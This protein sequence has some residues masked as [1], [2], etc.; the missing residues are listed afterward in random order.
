MKPVCRRD[1]NIGIRHIGRATKIPNPNAKVTGIVP[2]NDESWFDDW[3]TTDENGSESSYR[4]AT[5]QPQ[6]G[7]IFQGNA[8]KID[9]NIHVC[10][11][12]Q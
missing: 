12:I 8:K 10:V 3:T 2:D 11:I 9:C 7:K 4:T 1:N 6:N 5:S